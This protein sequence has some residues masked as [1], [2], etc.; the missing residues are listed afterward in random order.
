MNNFMCHV[1]GPKCK[2]KSSARRHK[3]RNALCKK[4]PLCSLHWWLTMYLWNKTLAIIRTLSQCF[5]SL[6]LC[7]SLNL[8][9]STRRLRKLVEVHLQPCSEIT[10]VRD[11]KL[12]YKL[13]SSETDIPKVN[14]TELLCIDANTC[15]H[16]R[17]LP[18]KRKIFF[19]AVQERSCVIKKTKTTASN[20]H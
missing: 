17:I 9:N 18:T 10:Q 8:A 19:I 5:R 1:L 20:E 11:T 6:P 4:S 16:R 13:F 12:D 15:G 14:L 7:E 2:C 3:R